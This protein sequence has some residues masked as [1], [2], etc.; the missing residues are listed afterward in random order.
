MGHKFQVRVGE[1]IGQSHVKTTAWKVA[2]VSL[3]Y[4][5]QSRIN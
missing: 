1:T 2:L 3:A 5:F 4:H